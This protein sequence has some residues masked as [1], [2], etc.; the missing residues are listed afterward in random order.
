MIMRKIRGGIRY[1]RETLRWLSFRRFC[2]VLRNSGV[3][4]TRLDYLP[5]GYLALLG[6]ASGPADSDTLRFGPSSWGKDAVSGHCFPRI[7][8]PFIRLEYGR[9]FDPKSPWAASSFQWA[10]R[11][12][13]SAP[14]D[15]VEFERWAVLASGWIARNPAGIGI[16]WISPMECS[17]R[18]VNLSLAASSW[19]PLLQSDDSL[20]AILARSIVEHAEF[21]SRNPEVKPGG[22]TTNHTTANYCGLLAC[23]LSVPGFHRSSPWVHQAA[24]G[25]ESCIARQVGREG[26]SFEGSIPYSFLVLDIFAHGAL[27]MRR[28]GI[29]PSSEYL[30][31]LRG[32]FDFILDVADSKGN[33]PQVGD[34]DSGEWVTPRSSGMVPML[35]CLYEAIYGVRP[36]PVPAFRIRGE[37]GIVSIRR[38]GFE[39][40]V[41]ACPVGQ[42]G[43]GGHNHEDLLQLCL[44]YRGI[45]VVV[46]PGTG[47]YN[48]DL[49]QRSLFRSMHVHNGP[50]PDGATHY[51]EFPVGAPFDLL[52]AKPVSTSLEASDAPGR[53]GAVIRATVDGRTLARIVRLDGDSIEVRDSVES[54]SAGTCGFD[55]KLTIDPR[56]T[57]R[58][59]GAGRL[60]LVS[61][62][63]ELEFQAGVPVHIV[64]GLYSPR[65]DVIVEAD[66]IIMHAEPGGGLLFR[67]VERGPTRTG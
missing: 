7:P 10:V 5:E 55:V 58:P 20:N 53:T 3:R 50:V 34:D 24:E 45:P 1:A 38:G 9:G 8:S 31:L 33:L 63:A 12:S 13:A 25:L 22:L 27:L 46:D 59:S 43:L 54:R 41:A 37:S 29:P 32:L 40:L 56:W 6:E 66:M 28:A 61:S 26:M 17:R 51:Y 42:E 2:R 30:G 23:A 35:A 18:V 60:T 47:S 62:G 11:Q 21:I 4:L 36:G 57:L 67:I 64:K 15:R 48:R 14:E 16:D 44:A 19:W 52:S 49:E 39:A 65:Y